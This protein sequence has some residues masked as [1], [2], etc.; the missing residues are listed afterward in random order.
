MHVSPIHANS[1]CTARPC[2][3]AYE[4]AGCL[5]R[6]NAATTPPRQTHLRDVGVAGIARHEHR[7]AVQA[8]EQVACTEVEK[9]GRRRMFVTRSAQGR[10]P[11]TGKRC[12]PCSRTPSVPSKNSAPER[13]TALHKHKKMRRAGIIA[14]LMGKRLISTAILPGPR[15]SRRRWGCRGGPGSWGQSRGR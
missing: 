13:S 14:W 6:N 9:S 8:S 12:S 11:T 10:Q 2:I 4:R 15:T 5:C 1:F 7:V 3:E